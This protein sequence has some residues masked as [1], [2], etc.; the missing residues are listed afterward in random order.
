MWISVW[1]CEKDAFIL[2]EIYTGGS[3][4]F[5]FGVEC[6][7]KPSLFTNKENYKIILLNFSEFADIKKKPI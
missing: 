4:V 7:R 5:A 6:F 2:L 1:G 3:D